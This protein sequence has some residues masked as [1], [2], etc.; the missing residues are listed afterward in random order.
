MKKLNLTIY[1]CT[2][3]FFG[4]YAQSATITGNVK[5]EAGE[6]LTGATVAVEG[7]TTGG[8]TDINGNYTFTIAPGTYTLVVSYVGYK[9][10]TRSVTAS[11]GN[12][13]Q[14]FVLKSTD[15][16][17][18]ELVIVGTRNQ[19]RT[20]TETPVPI[21]IIN[22]SQLTEL[23]AQT[24]INQILNY[25]APSFTSNPQT[26]ADG[27]DHIDPAQLRGLGPDQVL[28]LINGK[29]RH[30][31]SL[32]NVNGTVGTGSVGTDLNAIP[33]AAIERIEV[34]RD[35]AA[36]QYGSDAIAGV[37]N[38]VLKKAT[39]E[40]N[41]AIHRGANVSQHSNGYDVG[42][43]DGDKF[44]LDL[45]YGLP[46]AKG[47]YV[48]FTGSLSNRDATLRSDEMGQNIFL[49][50]NAVEWVAKED[51]YDL[52]Q[53]QY[54]M[55][56]IQNYAQ[57]VTHF[58]PQ[59][60]TDI[61]NAPD[62]ATLVGLLDDDVTDAELGV[63]GLSRSDFQMKVGQSK[64]KSGQFF[65]N[66]AVPLGENA[67]FYSFGGVS[68]RDGLAAGFYRR[69]A[70]TD[71]R[72][73]TPAFINGF[74]PH[75]GSDILDKS[76]A[77]G[78]RGKIGDWNVDLSNTYGSN[79]FAFSVLNTSNSTLGASTPVEFEAGGFQFSQNTSN[80]DISRYYDGVLN[81]LNLAFG[82]EFRLENY[83][84]FA[85]EEASWATYDINGN[86]I[87]SVTDP[88]DKVYSFYGNAIPGGSQVFPGYRPSNEVDKFRTS[89][90]M[91][92][93]IEADFSDKWMASTAMRYENYSDFG[94]TFNWKVASRY[95]INDNFALR[96]A[97]STGFRAPSLHQ[98]YFNATST[99]FIGGV[100]FEV[101]TFANNSRAAKLLG[102][103]EL[104]QELSLSKSIGF[105]ANALDNKLSFTV[106][107]YWINIQDRV[108]LTGNFSK[109]DPIAEPELWQLFEDASAN[110]AKFFANA[111]DTKSKGIDIVV[112]H[113]AEVGSGKLSNTLAATFFQ[114]LQDGA[115]KSSGALVGKE[116]VYFSSTA[117]GYLENASPRA[118]INLTHV[119]RADKF[120]VMLRNVY[121]GEVT[122]PSDNVTVYGSKIITD[123]TVSYT[124]TKGIKITLGGNNLLDVY[125]DEVPVGANYGGQFMF[126]RNTSQFGF[127]GRYVYS[128]LTFNLK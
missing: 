61:A 31:S 85:G 40:L 78:I 32:V 121:F 51:G 102:I 42:G 96:G 73:N 36:S 54:N 44:Q 62:M 113:D 81:G 104:K 105:T 94:D 76:M 38:I 117:R 99:Q 69:P 71:G 109:P 128:R 35:G 72:G 45:N 100:P 6:A 50:Y 77:V 11:D 4:V 83:K 79:R 103:P 8:S 48:N 15:L 5:D 33:T 53:L 56:D 57:T 89:Y 65:M 97:I 22:I 92:T 125:P 14:N 39:N 87:N 115:V 18:N 93:D 41:V 43:R 60:K 27:T 55:A 118:K 17:L 49:G 25:V 110:T 122:D 82:S 127:N 2:F 101:G 46:I 16:S 26:V 64:L 23:G 126:S 34:L 116:D 1:L 107:A 59:L 95:A 3:L 86:P 9:T 24:D 47:G 90:A 119:Y 98:I 120:S 30:S 29:R 20:V 10:L 108:V 84:L 7:T 68:Y 19:N 74:L 37:I 111:I 63:R 28:V 66:M 80:W 70:Y 52:S 112:S 114:T 88:A 13:V 106:D 12:N 91:Y 21:D 58:S 75:I 123:A 67:E 124:L